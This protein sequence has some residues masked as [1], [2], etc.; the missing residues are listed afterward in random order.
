[1][2]DPSKLLQSLPDAVVVITGNGIVCWGNTVAESLFGRSLADSLGLQGLDLVHPE[3]LELVLR[4]LESIQDKA[5]GSPIE[6]RL[7]TASGWRLMELIG[8]PVPWIDDGAVMLT[9]RDLTER[10]R[11]EVVH[12]QDARFRALVQNSPGITMLV[13]PLRLVESVSSALTRCL[14]H[15]PEEVEGRP[16]ATIVLEEDRALLESTFERAGR[17]ATAANPTTV[18]V[19]FLRRIGDDSVPFELAIVNLL[20][21]PTI[22]GYVVSAHDVTDLVRAGIEQERSLS[23]VNATLDATTEG[24]VVVDA[25]GR[26]SSFN[27]RFAEMWQVPSS[28]LLDRDLNAAFDF[29]RG[30]LVDPDTFVRRMQELS[31]NLQDGSE[32]M[33]EFLDGKVFEARSRLQRVKGEVVGRVWSFRDVTD[34]KRLEDRLSYQAF[35]D[36]LTGLGNRALFV[37][38]LEHALVRSRRRGGCVAVLFVDMD[39]FKYVNDNLGHAAGDLLLTTTAERLT[40]CLRSEDTAA[41]IGGDEF[42][43]VAEVM[44]DSEQALALAERILDAIRGP[45]SVGETKLLP[46]ASIGIAFDGHDHS[47]DQLL[48]RADI[49]M[50]QAKMKGG[51]T[52]AVFADEMLVNGRTSPGIIGG[53]AS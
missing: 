30:Q 22:G 21:D 52:C 36:S 16:L 39:R 3:D 17:G 25:F 45:V 1:M 27:A 7:Q 51:N 4:S 32:D 48:S 19:R 20:D 33:F 28:L 42:A 6:I 49:A 12:D 44:S 38:R 43:V 47:A 41:R 34:R 18:I 2:L 40:S 53:T 5:V 24:V 11:F 14:G 31:D 23:L 10:R 35:H 13:T 29:V 37:D 8:T 50:Y 15:D 9:L 46:T 26:F